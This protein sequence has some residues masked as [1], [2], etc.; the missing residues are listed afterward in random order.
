[1]GKRALHLAIIAFTV[2]FALT[3]AGQYFFASVENINHPGTK[4]TA[5]QS[6]QPFDIHVKHL[7]KAIEERFAA[8]HMPVSPL[9]ELF[10][11][12][13][14]FATLTFFPL[15]DTFSQATITALSPQRRRAL[16]RVFR[17]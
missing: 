5:Y 11:F 1:M 13:L 17:L 16:Q 14:L 8:P 2:I 6:G 12:S 3:R 10:L 4:V 15:S 9:A 7:E